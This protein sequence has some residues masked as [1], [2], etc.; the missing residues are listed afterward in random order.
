MLANSKF[1]FYHHQKT[2]PT[3]SP[4]SKPLYVM[5]KPA[6]ST[7]NLAC[8]YCY[9]LEKRKYYNNVC[10]QMS[11]ETLEAFIQ[12]Y[13]EA[14][15]QQEILFLWHGGEPLLRPLSFYKKAIMLQ[16]RYGRGKVIDNCLQTNGTLLTDEWCEFL[17]TNNWLVGISI[18]GPQEWHDAYRVSHGQKPTWQKV[19][20]GIEMLKKQGVE[21]NAMAVVNSL[22]VEHPAE[23][24]NFF[25]DIGCK[26]IQFAPIVERIYHKS[27]DQGLIPGMSHWEDMSTALK[28]VTPESISPVQWGRFLCEIY[29]LWANGDVGRIY[30]QIIEATL[31]NWVGVSPGICTLSASCGNAAAMEYN[32]DVYSCDHFVFPEYKLGNIHHQS[33]TAMMYGSQ[34]HDF[35]AMKQQ[36]LPHQCQEC[37]YKFACY[38]ECPKNRFVYDKYG[39]PGLNYLCK[40]YRQ[41]FRH[42]TDDMNYMAEEFRKQQM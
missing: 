30:I 25:K 9:Y 31:A 40:G 19:M 29:D 18:D 26:Y 13:I 35:S 32:G 21:W 27:D 37:E 16:K 23:F 33:L 15:T 12:Q 10:Q 3:I 24:Y 11:D 41:F 2:M 6:G 8:R 1:T 5:A 36:R 28:N 20:D 14:Q 39:G 42:V 4:F 34:Q 38:G 17:A 7:C 22:N